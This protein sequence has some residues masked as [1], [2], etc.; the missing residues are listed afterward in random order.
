[1]ALRM[2][3]Y[4]FAHARS[5]KRILD[6]GKRIKMRMPDARILYWESNSAT[7]ERVT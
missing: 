2:F 7:P 1:M 4:G 3:E 6:G 5:K